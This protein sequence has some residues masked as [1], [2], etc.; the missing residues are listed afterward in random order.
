MKRVT[1][2]LIS[3]FF[4]IL[5]VIID[6]FTKYLIIKNF[7]LGDEKKIIGDALV[8]KY[9]RN[10]GAAWGS[11]S[12]RIPLL[13]IFT[14]IA[15]I[16]LGIVYKNIIDSPVFL[17]LRICITAIYGGAIGNMIDRIRLGYVVDFIYA[18]VIKFPV[19]NFADICVTVS[20]FV[21]LYLFLFKYKSEDT[22]RI[23]NIKSSEDST[24]QEI[25][26]N[27]DLN[28]ENNNDNH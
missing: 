2:I 3:I 8:L 13:L 23:L 15:I 26:S 14:I 20:V 25:N 21:I 7:N 17:P 22:D 9:I 6:Q 11:L 24:K 28:N 4:I 12:G 19:F 16:F 10:T 1:K 18:K 5:L 27:D